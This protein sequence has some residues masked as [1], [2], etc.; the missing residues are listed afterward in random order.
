MFAG[1]F[2]CTPS[3][4]P[5]INKVY[6][7]L[8]YLIIP[9]TYWH[10]RRHTIQLCIDSGFVSAGTKTGGPVECVGPLPVRRGLFAVR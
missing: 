3:F 7:I 8:S 1:I 6:L 9:R 10:P 2:S 4:S 5:E